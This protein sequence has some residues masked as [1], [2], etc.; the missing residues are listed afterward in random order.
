MDKKPRAEVRGH[1]VVGRS[2]IS[3]ARWVV[4]KPGAPRLPPG[5]FMGIKALSVSDG[6]A[7]CIKAL[8][9]SEG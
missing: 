5:A 2:R 6:I 3:M 1:R 9:V 4:I 8:S 7:V